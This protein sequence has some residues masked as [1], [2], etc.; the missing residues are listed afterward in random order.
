M[1]KKYIEGIQWVLFYYYRGAQHWRWYYPFHY[2]P[3]IGDFGINLVKDFLGGNPKIVNFEVDYNCP[4]ESDPYTPFQQLLAIMPIRSFKLLPECYKK[5]ATNELKSFFPDDF[6]VDLNGKTLAWEAIV[7]IPFVDQTI[8]LEAEAKMLSSGTGSFSQKDSDR[9]KWT[10]CYHNYIY[11]SS[12]DSSGPLLSTLTNLKALPH[13]HTKQFLNT[14]YKHVG[15]SSFTPTLLPGCVTPCVGYPS[16]K[17][18]NI[19]LM[20][21]ETIVVRKVQFKKMLVKIPQCIEETQPEKL[22]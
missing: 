8:F 20:T 9:N 16:F 12:Q 6:S 7:L 21:F 19:T 15:E 1:M 11:D 13:N 3:L 17:Q 4:E 2:A 22:E 14:D 18:L 5:I 10:F